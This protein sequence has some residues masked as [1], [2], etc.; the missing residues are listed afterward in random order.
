MVSLRDSSCPHAHVAV[1][2]AYNAGGAGVNVSCTYPLVLLCSM[3][4]RAALLKQ[5][6]RTVP[7]FAFEKSLI[8]K[9]VKIYWPLEKHWYLGKITRFCA[10]LSKYKI[11]YEVSSSTYGALHKT[12][13]R[14]SACVTC[15]PWCLHCGRMA[16]KSGCSSSKSK[17]ASWSSGLTAMKGRGPCFER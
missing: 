5:S 17:T 9:N 7:N 6:L 12:H 3:R 1:T 11:A 16:G 8:G 14:D 15:H 13:A 2:Y 10:S 4:V